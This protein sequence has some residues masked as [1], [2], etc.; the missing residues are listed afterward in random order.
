[1]IGAIVAGTLSA[2]TAPVTNSYE[3][4]ATVTVGSGGSSSV[5]FSSIPSTFKH[6]QIRA[7]AR[8][9]GPY[10]Y[11]QTNMTFNS[12]NGSNYSWHQVNGNGSGTT[13]NGGSSTTFMRI[14][15]ETAAN[16]NANC[17]GGMV[18]DILD[19]ADTNKNKTARSLWGYEDN[20]TGTVGLRSGNWRS[21]SAVSS[22]TLV[23]SNDWLQYSTFAL[24]GIKG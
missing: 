21:T 6:L 8:A 2:P 16:N 15:D 4:I 5:S 24:Y 19:Y 9:S 20:S 22:I 10:T 23:C 3:S 1:M 18:I 17:F 11:D 12:D 7:I 13:S 14:A